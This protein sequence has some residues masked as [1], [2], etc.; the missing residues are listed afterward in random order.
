[1]L[2]TPLGGANCKIAV[3][4]LQHLSVPFMSTAVHSWYRAAAEL[5]VT[6]FGAH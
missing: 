6:I 3:H 4:I 2:N 5:A 1:M